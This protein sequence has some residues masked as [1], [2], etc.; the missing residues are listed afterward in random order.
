MASE[1]VEEYGRRQERRAARSRRVQRQQNRARAV[2]E[3]RIEI[4]LRGQVVARDDMCPYGVSEPGRPRSGHK[5]RR[6]ASQERKWC[7]QRMEDMRRYGMRC[8]RWLLSRSAPSTSASVYDESRIGIVVMRSAGRRAVV[9]R[10]A[11]EV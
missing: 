7:H 3:Q 1:A 11:G 8:E 10:R 4:E 2:R 5:M 6:R 9:R